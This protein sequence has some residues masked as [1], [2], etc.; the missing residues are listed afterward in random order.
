MQ[1]WPPV[2]IA[3][4]LT[5]SS[6]L[7]LENEVTTTKIVSSTGLPI[8]GDPFMC[9]EY[10]FPQKSSLFKKIQSSL[11]CNLVGALKGMICGSKSH[12]THIYSRQSYGICFKALLTGLC[13][14]TPS[15]DT[16]YLGFVM[17]CTG[18]R[19]V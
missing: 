5:G 12:S 3:L 18:N 6:C 14:Q 1:P 9:P 13:L 15:M 19:E 17:L 10:S 7:P 2:I 16:K 4:L 8:G 11:P